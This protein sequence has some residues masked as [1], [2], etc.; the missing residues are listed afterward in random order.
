[1]RLHLPAGVASLLE[2]GEGLRISLILPTDPVDPAGPQNRLRYRNL[3]R[4]AEQQAQADGF[5][6]GAIARALKPA[7]DLL[8]NLP[9][10]QHLG[11][12][13][14]IYTAEGFL[15]T[16]RLPYPVAD[17]LLVGA[18][19]LITPLVPLIAEDRAF[20]VLALSRGAVRLLHGTREDM[21]E[22][23]LPATVPTD[24]A[25]ALG[26]DVYETEHRYVAGASAAR[27]RPGAIFY[28]QGSG[29]T[30]VMVRLQHY[31]EQV[32]R[33]LHDIGGMA[34]APLVLAGDEEILA[35]YRQVTSHPHVLPSGVVTDPDRLSAAALHERAWPI[36]EAQ[37][38]RE[39]EQIL[40]RYH[41][42]L[43]T[44]LAS[45]DPA[46]V[47]PA[48]HR[49]RIDTLL[50]APEEAC[51]GTFTAE[52]GVLDLHETAVPGDVDM[53]NRA[54]IQT[55]GHGGMVHAVA[56]MALPGPV[57]FAAIFRY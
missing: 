23:P 5:E 12:G 3:I 24:L 13:L 55:L 38:R 7:Y 20:Y 47:V 44:G 53:A 22:V 50:L 54:T 36:I 16:Y 26:V 1:M 52:T 2:G 46:E 34:D 35:M 10:W 42:L 9:F 31:C 29:G 33:G 28:G 51:A 6:T 17:R 11:R 19:F 21:D 40:D 57:P 27:G 49:G 48:A 41:R 4:A 18:E 8:D 37:L 45:A 43:G 30:E 25:A 32:D 15:R 39:G 56:R 14:A